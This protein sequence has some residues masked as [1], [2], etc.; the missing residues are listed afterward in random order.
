MED[1]IEKL[2][3]AVEKMQPILQYLVAE[4]AAMAAIIRSLGTANRDNAAF[5]AA[6]KTEAEIRNVRQLN[7]A[8][9]DDDIAAFKKSLASLL[10]KQP[11]EL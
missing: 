6:L 5:Q 2:V 3:S 7:S 11:L 10:P 8:M 1:K 9:S 4:N